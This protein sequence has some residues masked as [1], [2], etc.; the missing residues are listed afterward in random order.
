MCV[1]E[2]KYVCV[3]TLMCSCACAYMCACMQVRMCV[4][5]CVCLCM[6]EYTR[7]CTRT[8]LSHVLRVYHEQSIHNMH[9]YIHTRAIH[10]AL[11]SIPSNSDTNMCTQHTY[12]H[13]SD[14]SNLCTTRTPGT[15]SPTLLIKQSF[16]FAFTPGT[17]SSPDA[18][19]TTTICAHTLAC[20]LVALRTSD[21][22]TH[23]NTTAHTNIT[24]TCHTHAYTYT[25]RPHTHT[26][27]SRVHAPLNYVYIHYAYIHTHN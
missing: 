1:R 3:N 6:R 10:M 11:P 13:V 2:R 22:T 27:T 18:F 8:C 26:H 21:K 4:C 19:S 7:T 16:A 24:C 15:N 25:P 5:V 23:T 17:L 9:T 20:Q 12:I 14:L